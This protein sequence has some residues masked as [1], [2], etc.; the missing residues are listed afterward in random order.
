VIGILL[1]FSARFVQRS[2]FFDLDLESV[3]QDSAKSTWGTAPQRRS[4]ASLIDRKG[5][6]RRHNLDVAAQLFCR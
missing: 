2:P 5:G 4:T 1:M 3:S 6:S